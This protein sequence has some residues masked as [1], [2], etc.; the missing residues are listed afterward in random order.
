MALINSPLKHLAPLATE[1]KSSTFKSNRQ[2]S[3]VRRAFFG[4]IVVDGVATPRDLTIDLQD[5]VASFGEALDMEPEPSTSQLPSSNNSYADLSQSINTPHVR[6]RATTITSRS[7]TPASPVDV[8]SPQAILSRKRASTI[9]AGLADIVNELVTTERSYVRRLR[10]LQSEYANP[11]RSFSKNRSTLILP[12][13]EAKVIFGNIDQILP[14]NEALLADLEEM[15]SPD[16][17]DVGGIGD[18]A[19][20]HF[21]DQKGFEG[22]SVYYS[23]REEAQ[24]MFEKELKRVTG[25]GSFS[26]FIER[27]KYSTGDARN[28]IGLRELLMEP[29]QRIP[30]YTLLFGQMIKQMPAHDPQRAKLME[31]REQASKI[32]H[33][34]LDEETKRA[35]TMYCLK[36]SIE[37]FPDSLWSNSRKFVDCID[38]IDILQTGALENPS[39]PGGNANGL[40]HCSLILFDDKLLIAKRSNTEKPSRELLGLDDLDKVAMKV[41][42]MSSGPKKHGMEYKGVVEVTDIVCTDNGGSGASVAYIHLYLESPPPDQ[43]GV[44]GPRHFRPLT[45]VL[46]PATVNLD[47]VQVE[48]VKRRF[49]DNLWQV[50]ARY[51]TRNGQSVL[52]SGDEREVENRNDMRTVARL[53]YNLYPR[54][55]FMRE[56]KKTKIVVQVDQ[57][58]AAD[59]VEFGPK[60]PFVVVRIQP[61]EGNLAR[62]AVSSYYQLDDGEEEIVQTDTVAGRVADI[63]YQYGLFTFKTGIPSNSTPATPSSARTLTGILGVDTIARSLFHSHAKNTS[64]GDIFGGSM[65]TSKR[66][67]TT[68]ASRASANTASTGL[69]ADTNSIS[70]FVRSRSNSMSTAATSALD[71]DSKSMK[72]LVPSLDTGSWGSRRSGIK[73]KLLKTRRSK[74][75]MTAGESGSE[76]EPVRCASRQ[77]SDWTD[78]DDEDEFEEGKT[79]SA[80]NRDSSDFDL[81]ERLE[82]ARKNSQ[83]QIEQQYGSITPGEETIYEYEDEPPQSLRSSSRASK[84]LP[85]IPDDSN[86]DSSSLPL[87]TD[88]DRS[89]PGRPSRPESRT[90]DRRPRGPRTPSPLPPPV[91][92]RER[93]GATMEA[94]DTLESTFAELSVSQ[95]GLPT[96]PIPRSRRQV[97]DPTTLFSNIAGPSNYS[98]GSDVP[99]KPIQPL[100]VVKRRASNNSHGSSPYRMKQY[101]VSR[102]GTPHVKPASRKTSRSSLRKSSAQMKAIRAQV[103]G[104]ANEEAEKLFEKS[105][106]IKTKLETSKSNVAKLRAL[107]EQ[108][109]TSEQPATPELERSVSPVKGLRSLMTRAPPTAPVTKEAKA[110]MEEMQRVIQRRGGDI[111]V[112]PRRPLSFHPGESPGRSPF[113]RP[114]DDGSATAMNEV[115]KQIDS[116]LSEAL[117]SYEGVQAALKATVLRNMELSSQLVKE[118]SEAFTPSRAHHFVKELVDSARDELNAM[119]DSFNEELD[120]VFGG[121]QLPEGDNWEAV[122]NALKRMKLEKKESD[123]RNKLLHL[124]LADEQAHNDTYR[125]MLRDHGIIY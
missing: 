34:D 10:L 28:R 121:L 39:T 30:R 2:S 97:F 89:E 99:I 104:Y 21:R 63:I 55:W 81:S 125:Q 93:S 38:V 16:G 68:V 67:R 87:P 82:L 57:S 96:T 36:T 103:G 42:S 115:T 109:K 4:A 24:T 70:R 100:T 8:P 86:E 41:K 43:K 94:L 112:T 35:S 14:V 54:T 46:P 85:N 124:R 77:S 20:S 58:G 6:K 47:P 3:F 50:Q 13:Y 44:W 75:P 12:P 17:R 45:I 48:R 19:L 88:D 116:D 122:A 61:L 22:Y 66:S 76:P 111:G 120:N 90:G 123:R 65:N 51:R 83:S 92:T 72:S 53:Y 11:L 80:I 1:P 62:F 113:E 106:V 27:V 60:G 64:K 71:D 32:A 49:L 114:K 110:R 26:Q 40:Y 29:V 23:K 108:S 73:R 59:P 84:Q 78:A 98:I 7:S 18:V 74:S 95:R 101:N 56:P 102:G 15:I 33:A 25:Q 119:Y 9:N 79:V 107:Y 37:G 5:L 118:K 91:I 52:L 117:A 69:T 31:A 105:E